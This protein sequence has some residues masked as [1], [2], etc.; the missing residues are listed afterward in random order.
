MNLSTVNYLNK[1]PAELRKLAKTLND[2]QEWTSVMK[3]SDHADW[4]NKTADDI[5]RVLNKKKTPFEIANYFREVSKHV[6]TVVSDPAL[7]MTADLTMSYSGSSIF[8]RLYRISENDCWRPG[9]YS[10]SSPQTIAT[11]NRQLKT[12]NDNALELVMDVYAA[13]LA[14]SEEEEEYDDEEEYEGA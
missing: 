13:M 14:D 7:F 11:D 1:Q 9:A 5:D 12:W 4:L 8:F 6:L 3:K 2:T 10:S